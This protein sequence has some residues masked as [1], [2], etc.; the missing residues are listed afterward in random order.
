MLISLHNF[1]NRFRYEYLPLC[2]FYV[3]F[4]M[5]L[6]TIAIEVG[7]DFLRKLHFV[8]KQPEDTMDAEI[9]FGGKKFVFYK[10]ISVGFKKNY[11]LI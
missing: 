11:F 5:A 3:T 10:I 4:G 7:S 6:T 8:G 1:K 2:L 9:W